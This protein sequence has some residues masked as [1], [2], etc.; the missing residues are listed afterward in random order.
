MLNQSRIEP[1]LFEKYL[2]W[3]KYKNSSC[4]K[5]IKIISN[6]SDKAF[7]QH[8]KSIIVDKSNT[9]LALWIGDK[10]VACKANK[11]YL[12]WDLNPKKTRTVFTI[13]NNLNLNI[14]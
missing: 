4:L 1:I 5:Q 3:D 13:E 10:I 7:F 14:N 8:I 2:F 12:S 9:K 6:L 11:V